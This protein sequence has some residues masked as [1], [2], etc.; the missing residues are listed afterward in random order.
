MVM[1]VNGTGKTTSVAKIT[2]FLA[3]DG[4]KVLLAASDTFRAAAVEQLSRWTDKLNLQFKTEE[5]AAKAGGKN[6]SPVPLTGTAT[7]ASVIEIVK[8][9]QGADPASVAHDACEK[10]LAKGFDYV[11]ID[12]AGR[13]H[14]AKNLMT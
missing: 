2:R 14:T 4:K 11:I 13:L 7:K 1:G 9:E 12:T 6:G 3:R 5:A 8:G 10:A